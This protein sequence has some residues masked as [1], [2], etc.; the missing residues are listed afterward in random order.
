MAAPEGSNDDQQAVTV[1]HL[2]GLPA[3]R[4]PDDDLA[5]PVLGPDWSAELFR[6]IAADPRLRPDL[7]VVAGNLAARGRKWEYDQAGRHIAALMELFG[8]PAH[9]IVLVP[10]DG[11]VNREASASYFMQRAA[12][13]DEAEPPYWP[14]WTQFAA[15][16][17]RFYQDNPS[18]SFAPGEPWS[19]F[20]ISDLRVVVAGLNSTMAHSHQDA[21]NYGLIGEQQA[22]WFRSRLARYAGLGWLRIGLLRH[23]PPGGCEHGAEHLRDAELLDRLIG[24]NLN[25]LAH[26]SLVGPGREDRAGLPVLGAGGRAEPGQAAKSTGFELLRIRS[27]GVTR[28]VPDVDACEHPAASLADRLVREDIAVA[29]EAVGTT[30]PSARRPVS[31]VETPQPGGKARRVEDFADRV[32]EICAL[33][34]AGSTIVAVPATAKAPMY[35]RVSSVEDTFVTQRPVGLAENGVNERVLD[36]FVQ[37]VHADFAAADPY[38]FSEF[39][40]GGAPA[41]EHLAAAAHKR[42][43]NLLSFVEYQGLMDLRGY[44]A[45]QTERLTNSR[46]YPPATYVPQRYR[47]IGT[48]EIRQDLLEQVFGWVESD[49]Q[50]FV[51]LLGDF[52]LGKTFLMQEL[53]RR[54]PERLPHVVPMLLELRT[55]EK[56]RSVDELVAQHLAFSGEKRINLEAFRYMLRSGRIVLLF[57]G[58]DEL[59][60]RVSYDRAADRLQTLLQGLEGRAKLIISSRSQ[61]FMST[62]QVLTALGERVERVHSSHLVELVDF[63]DEQIREYLVRLYRGDQRLADARL[64][65]IKE[66]RDLLGLSRNPRMLGFISNL[67][68]ARL[69]QVQAREGSI[70]SADLYRELL[71]H[72]FRHEDWRASP[73]GASSILTT[74]DRWRAVRALAMRLWQSVES[75]VAVAELEEETAAALGPLADRFLDHDQAAQLV[76]SG[77]LLVRDDEGRFTFVHQSVLE[78]LIA[79]EAARQVQTEDHRSAILGMRPISP[80]MADFFAGLAGRGRAVEC[81]RRVLDDVAATDVAKRNALLI[82]DRVG[83]QHAAQARLSGQNLR[84]SV[85]AGGDLNRADLAGADLTAARLVQTNLT[86]ASLRDAQLVGA[87][88]NR[89]TL[90]DADLVGAD[91]TEARLVSTDL[92]GA[93]LTGSR[94]S[95]ASL[96]DVTVDPAA[97]TGPELADAAIAGRDPAVVQRPPAAAPARGVSFAP[98]G[99]LLAY[100]MGQ[101]VVIAGPDGGRLHR[102]VHGHTDAVTAVAFSPDGGLLASASLDGTVRVWRAEDVSLREVFDDAS[103]QVFSVVFSP[104][105]TLLAAG[106]EDG[107]VYLWRVANGTL[108]RALGQGGPAVYAVAFSPD[109]TLVATA[110]LDGNVRLWN[111]ADGSRGRTLPVT[112]R[113]VLA[114]AFSPEGSLLATGGGDGKARL[115]RVADG[116]IRDELSAHIRVV[117]GVA[118]SSDGT[119]FATCGGDGNARL[120][121]VADGSVVAT[122]SG[123]DDEVHSVAYGPD[124]DLLATAGTDGTVRVW[125]VP[126][127]ARRF[128]L[129]GR[130]NDINDLAVSVDG[131]FVA[132]GTDDGRV[133]LWSLSGGTCAIPYR[134][135]AD[136]VFGDGFS[137]DGRL[138]AIGCVKGTV[139]L[140]QLPDGGPYVSPAGAPHSGPVRKVVFSHDNTMLATAAAE[141]RIRLWR[142]SDA[143]RLNTLASPTRTVAGLTFARDDRLLVT[144]G[145]DETIQLWNVED[146]TWQEPLLT[147]RTR[148][149]SALAFNPAGS[150]LASGG[151][152]GT[153]QLWRFADR[154][155]IETMHAHRGW[156][157]SVAF[158]HDGVFF[159]TA[160]QDETLRVWRVSD[161]AEVVTLTGHSGAVYDVAF[162]S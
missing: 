48:D 132:T 31:E 144:A 146:G 11:D 20:E 13:D 150:L 73:R 7:L 118:F 6:L 137:P 15:Q 35:L 105:G 98:N 95:G 162:C 109:G 63:T 140:R 36:Q 54:M 124:G 89:V 14:K 138:L 106:S 64:D 26:G 39:V 100:G 149:V 8:L 82:Q 47:V 3:F 90:V 114:V 2:A 79:E 80:L 5:D 127:H 83:V 61:H 120:W 10:G 96:L 155:R 115:W 22:E 110:C 159:A 41:D 58:F 160:G 101:T 86:G 93:V 27:D 111:V 38:L 77:T 157:H 125:S 1:L 135:H 74:E 123:H 62:Q 37:H 156:V 81:A 126:A 128:T 87:A 21:D 92:T 59:A 66:I 43:I 45:R 33:R 49:E 142:V 34:H 46:L 25:L 121:N 139:Q 65:L 119:Q 158:S 133:R 60:L 4:R 50:Q 104:D 84:G 117:L 69:R 76:G 53:A 28:Y 12:E 29:F 9:R 131:Q 145:G 97:R 85:M 116:A 122:L 44:L 42:G 148:V 17:G 18:V 23:A 40:Y 16:F 19:L 113:P 70:S 141:G 154:T 75:T 56:A 57:D 30:F 129:T 52:G 107:G 94:W 71:D 112:P 143:A 78:W 67:D 161:G 55:L 102:C 134:E 68:E 91:F 153:V 72:W 108:H 88:L 51:L 147:G 130:Q 32:K 99:R 151:S 136:A 24:P 152:D 103:G